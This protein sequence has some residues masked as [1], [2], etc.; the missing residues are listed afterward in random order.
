M[1][2]IKSKDNEKF[3]AIKSLLVSKKR[4]KE[5]K[6]LAEGLRTVELALEHGADI[7]MVIL[8]EG[9][10]FDL[11]L[12][13]FKVHTLSKDLYDQVSDTENSQGIMVVVKMRDL[14]KED[15]DPSRHR[16]VLVLDRL[17]DPGNVGTIIRTADAMGFDLICMTKGCV[18][19][20]NPKVVR[21]AMGSGFYMDILL[22]SQEAILSILK[23]A[24][25]QIVSSSLDTDNYY[26]EVTYGDGCA[27]VL[28]NEANG[29]NDFWIENSDLLVKI[30]MY[31]KAESFNV[32]I[33]AALLM[34]KVIKRKNK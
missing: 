9:S 32:A 30:P 6:Y 25:L 10:E 8:R 34:S 22:E 17:Q 7:D 28:G 19:V 33:S 2:Y 29:I 13:D 1:T 31:G 27:L 5:K 26:D 24:G 11:D 20:Y 15:F 21:S 16:K 23:G 4:Y 14:S 18:D 12:K 3:K